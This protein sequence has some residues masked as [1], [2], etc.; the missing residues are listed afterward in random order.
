M[1]PRT[2]WIAIVESEEDIQFLC[3][4][5]SIL[6]IT[7][8]FNKI[9]ENA[10]DAMTN[11]YHDDVVAEC[12]PVIQNFNYFTGIL[13]IIYKPELVDSANIAHESVH[14]SDYYF[15]ITGMNNEDFSTGGNEGYAYL[16]GWV[17]GCFVK[18][19]KDMERQS[20]EDSLALWEFEKNNVKQFGSNISEELK[21]LMEVADKK[22]NNC[23][24]T[25]NEFMDD[26]LEGLAKLKDTDS[27]E[28]R[29]LQIKGL[30]NCLTNKYIEDG[31]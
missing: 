5:F 14:I 12:R 25:Y 8:E 4:K 20:K 9:L 15:E 10:Q 24:L 13:C 22:I 7:P 18:V 26:I 16:V 31:E 6:E 3:K 27:I 28:T 17:A 1:Y 23:S 2:L 11:A 30:Y 29:Q 21:E 19:M